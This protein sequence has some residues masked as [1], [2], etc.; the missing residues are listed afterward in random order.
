VPERDLSRQWFDLNPREHAMPSKEF[1]QPEDTFDSG[2]FGFTQVVTSAPGKLVFV[3]GQVGLDRDLKLVGEGDVAAQAKQALKN[4]GISLRAAGAA[5]A[6][7]TMLR[8][9]I[10]DYTP[11]L[12]PGLAPPFD[13][14]FHGRPPA[15]TRVGV[16]ALAAPGLL[17]GIEAI[18]V[19]D[20]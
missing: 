20:A 9:Y 11:E 4:L 18:A 5:P 12:A 8:T 6:D 13:E 10:V 2:R 1:I 16:Q 14:F 3:S 15:S 17:I 19:I 7:V